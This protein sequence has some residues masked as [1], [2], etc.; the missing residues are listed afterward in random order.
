MD[1]SD[2][3]ALG[4]EKSRF[5]GR[6]ISEVGSGSREEMEKMWERGGQ[7]AEAI[8]SQKFD[9]KAHDPAYEL[10]GRGGEIQN[11]NS[12]AFT[13]GKAMGLDLSAALEAKE[14]TRTFSGWDRD[15][16]DPKYK[17]YVAPP[18][19]PVTNAP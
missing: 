9:Y 2:L 18:M 12:V 7:A 8:N 1:G 13:L 3:V 15:L 6:K 11:S 16:L 5:G 19:F 14:M 10:G 4:N 17:R